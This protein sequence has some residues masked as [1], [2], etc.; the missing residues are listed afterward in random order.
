MVLPAGIASLA[1]ETMAVNVTVGG[2]NQPWYVTGPAI[3]VVVV[4][5]RPEPDVGVGGR[6]GRVRARQTEER[7]VFA[8][9]ELNQVSIET[10]QGIG[11]V[12]VIS[13]ISPRGDHTSRVARLL[14]LGPWRPRRLH[15]RRRPLI[16]Q[17]A[18]A[19]TAVAHGA[20]GIRDN[21]VPN[22]HRM[23]CG[24]RTAKRT[25][26]SEHSLLGRSL[27]KPKVDC[28]VWLQVNDVSRF[29]SGC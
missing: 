13:P 22:S 27:P 21:R 19:Q 1:D 10:N 29:A 8:G 9:V 25:V 16:V 14:R 23:T 7:I 15:A 26:V 5:I 18:D 24:I 28:K 12:S 20:A 2:E 4:A 17:R 11:I 3:S 6:R